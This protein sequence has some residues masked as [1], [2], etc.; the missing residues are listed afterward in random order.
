VDGRVLISVAS[1]SGDGIDPERRGDSRSCGI[2][3][4]LTS[5]QK[6][7]NSSNDH[8][9]PSGHSNFEIF[10]QER[11]GKREKP[12]RRALVGVASFTFELPKK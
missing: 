11:I 8:V 7:Y 6:Q 10:I 5:G 9:I 4:I 2:F 12:K 1:A 3:P